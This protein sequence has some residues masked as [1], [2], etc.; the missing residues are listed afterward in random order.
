MRAQFRRVLGWRMD[1]GGVLCARP[2]PLGNPFSDGPPF[3]DVGAFET[4][5]RT[6]LSTP[7]ESLDFKQLRFVEAFHKA[8]RATKL[9]CFCRID[10][11]CHVDAIRRLMTETFKPLT[12]EVKTHGDSDESQQAE[13]EGL[14]LARTHGSESTSIPV[15]FGTP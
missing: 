2:G 1:T 13:G 14:Q 7:R 9:Y 12:P 10:Q 6:A 15:Y 3:A 5:A 4:W 8:K 11:P